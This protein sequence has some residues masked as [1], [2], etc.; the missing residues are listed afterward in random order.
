MLSLMQELQYYLL[1]MIKNESIVHNTKNIYIPVQ[2]SNKVLKKLVFV[3][4]IMSDGI[5]YCNSTSSFLICTNCQPL[6][7]I[8]RSGWCSVLLIATCKQDS[9]IVEHLARGFCYTPR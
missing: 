4:I 1:F 9:C 6:V 5:V 3:A 8:T 7:G 2:S